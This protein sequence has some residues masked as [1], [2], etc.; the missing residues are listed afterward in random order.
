MH[1]PGSIIGPTFTAANARIIT[2]FGWSK[3]AIDRYTRLWL[4]VT[5]TEA[6]KLETQPGDSARLLFLL[7]WEV[8]E[9]PGAVIEVRSGTGTSYDVPGARWV[10]DAA[11]QALVQIS[12][13]ALAVGDELQYS[14][15]RKLPG[16]VRAD[17]T[18]AL[19]A[20]AHII[21]TVVTDSTITDEAY[22]EAEAARRLK[23]QRRAPQQVILQTPYVNV[24]PDMAC[25][26]TVPERLVTGSYLVQTVDTRDIGRRLTESAA[27]VSTITLIE[28]GE[29]VPT[30]LDFW[31]KTTSG[32]GGGT[33]TGGGGGGTGTPGPPGP[34]GVTYLLGHLGGSRSRTRTGTGPVPEWVPVIIDRA[35]LASATL[36]VRTEQAVFSGGGT[37]RPRL[38]ALLG[39]VWTD[40]GHGDDFVSGSSSAFVYREFNATAQPG[41]VAYRLELETSLAETSAAGIGNVTGS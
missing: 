4:A 18:E 36:R 5:V 29:S 40:V 39:S 35:K 38:M 6:L 26:V 9:P 11:Q 17:D 22:A 3:Q 8:A 16:W 13:P 15:L 12:G 30:W 7:R 21:E 28:G 10:Y 27:L 2:Q 23:L 31:R 37:V 25:T 20:G 33:I 24:F 1:A 41:S 14:Y 34:A 19:A 32:G